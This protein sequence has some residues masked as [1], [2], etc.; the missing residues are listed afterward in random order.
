MKRVLFP[1]LSDLEN[2]L[3]CT[4]Q[5]GFSIVIYICHAQGG[6]HPFSREKRRNPAS[7]EPAF[8]KMEDDKFPCDLDL[9]EALLGASV[10]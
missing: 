6:G 7:T 2:R 5:H 1:I 8:M 9:G 3:H 10:Y 4:E